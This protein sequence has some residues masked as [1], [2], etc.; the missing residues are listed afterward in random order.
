[1]S[2]FINGLLFCI[3]IADSLSIAYNSVRRNKYL[4]LCACRNIY[5]S[6]GSH[7]HQLMVDELISIEAEESKRQLY[8]VLRYSKFE[9]RSSIL[10]LGCLVNWDV[11]T[12][13]EY[14]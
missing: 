8:V 11:T 14:E 3:Y 5:G 7:R 13:P 6:F 10:I 2:S 9:A 1:M 4:N 12:S